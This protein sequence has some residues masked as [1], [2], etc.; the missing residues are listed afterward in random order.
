M[1]FLSAQSIRF[2]MLFQMIRI[3]SLCSKI[4]LTYRW[5]ALAYRPLG[6]QLTNDVIW[7]TNLHGRLL[8]RGSKR[9]N[10]TCDPANLHRTQQMLVFG[11]PYLFTRKPNSRK[12]YTNVNSLL[13]LMKSLVTNSVNYSFK[14]R[15]TSILRKI[16]N[17][18]GLN[19]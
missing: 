4:S 11:S 3:S 14:S 16:S 17:F 18:P 1:S 15:R 12:L 2:V 13:I 9:R 6:P 5:W 19:N 10:S 7:A 8:G